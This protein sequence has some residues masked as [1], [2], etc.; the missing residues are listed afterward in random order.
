MPLDS[1]H[2]IIV[3]N[4]GKKEMANTFSKELI[5]ILYKYIDN[6]EIKNNIIKDLIN[7]IPDSCEFLK[8][9]TY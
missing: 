4:N 7:K 8:N 3:F 5:P 2:D 1:I 6:N 9:F